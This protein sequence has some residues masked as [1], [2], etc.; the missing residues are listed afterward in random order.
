MMRL[1]K[2][3]SI[4]FKVSFYLALAMMVSWANVFT[5]VLETRELPGSLKAM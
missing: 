1:S 2:L 3:K 5:L 4:E